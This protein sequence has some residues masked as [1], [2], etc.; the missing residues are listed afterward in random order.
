MAKC[1]LAPRCGIRIGREVIV[2]DGPVLP[3]AGS[4][5]AHAQLALDFDSDFGQVDC[6][7][8]ARGR[9][10]DRT[11]FDQ[12]YP[13]Q[14]EFTLLGDD[15]ANL[16]EQG[17]LVARS[18]DGF[19]D[20]AKHRIQARE[21]PVPDLYASGVR[22]RLPLD[23]G[24]DVVWV[25]QVPCAIAPVSWPCLGKEPRDTLPLGDR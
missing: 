16:G 6:L 23:H 9:R 14:R 5:W 8:S 17:L 22:V 7:W 12:P 25:M 18:D 19:V 1:W 24:Q 4:G 21:T 11:L 2:D 10:H 3:N 20:L 15:P 13:G